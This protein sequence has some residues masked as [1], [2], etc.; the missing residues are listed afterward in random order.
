MK[1]IKFDGHNIVLAEDQPEYQPLP[2][3][4]QFNQDG[5]CVFVW[6]L[7]DE[8]IEVLKQTKKMYVCQLTF[9]QLFQPILPTVNQADV[10]NDDEIA[11]GE[12]DRKRRE[13]EK[14]LNRLSGQN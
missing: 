2:V 1:P 10:L 13:H 7:T 9:N 8:E 6:E 3:H 4:R 5:K 12:H 11:W 14:E